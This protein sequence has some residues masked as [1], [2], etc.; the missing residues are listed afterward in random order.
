MHNYT[1]SKIIGVLVTLGLL[2]AFS[3]LAMADDETT[4]DPA[5]AEMLEKAR[6]QERI[7]DALAGLASENW[8][9]RRESLQALVGLDDER[10]TSVLIDAANAKETGE[11]RAFAVKALWHHAADLQ[12]ADENVNAALMLIAEEE[13]ELVSPIAI[14]ALDDMD[15][16][17]TRQSLLE[18]EN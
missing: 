12:F 10:A 15:Q 2:V 9:P 11:E 8:M 13:D 5:A 16:Y 14:E 3:S 4:L 6:L 7:D 17:L 18:A 1:L